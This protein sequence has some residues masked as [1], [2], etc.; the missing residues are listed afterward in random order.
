MQSVG[1]WQNRL[2][3]VTTVSKRRI[4]NMKTEAIPR[5]PYSK[6]ELKQL[7]LAE[8]QE[9]G[10]TDADDEN[11]SGDIGNIEPETLPGGTNKE[12]DIPDNIPEE[13]EEE[14]EDRR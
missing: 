13:D 1:N 11:N 10:S 14:E 2:Y 8:T 4:K 12:R 9:T 3:N 6:E 5:G 7:E